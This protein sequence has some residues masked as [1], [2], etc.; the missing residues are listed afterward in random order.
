MDKVIIS[1]VCGSVDVT[2]YAILGRMYLA[3]YGVFMLFLHP[4]WA[5]YGETLKRGDLE[6]I[7]R[8]VWR[9]SWGGC[10]VMLLCTVVLLV[11][12]Q[13]LMA[14]L[15]HGPNSTGSAVEVSRSLILACGLTFATRAWVDCRSVVLLSAN[16]FRPQILFYTGHAVLNLIVAIPAAKYWGVEGVA[17]STPITAMLTSVWGYPLLLKW[18]IY[19]DKIELAPSSAI[20]GPMQEDTQ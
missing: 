19:R 12:G 20:S 7:K 2:G 9:T 15:P 11:G 4:L 8:M 16:V 6:W 10:G 13:R 3:G 14:L 18:Y 17:W 5:A 1:S